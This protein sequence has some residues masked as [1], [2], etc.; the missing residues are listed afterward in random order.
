MNRHPGTPS[1]LVRQGPC[2]WLVFF[3]FSLLFTS[4]RPTTNWVAGMTDDLPTPCRPV[5][6]FVRSQSSTFPSLVG[7]YLSILFSV[8]LPFLFPGISVP[9]TFLSV[10]VFFV[11]PRHMSLPVRH[12]FSDLL[13]SLRH[14]RCPS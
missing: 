12:S 9:N 3:I 5:H 11:S 1:P 14:S 6:H 7:L 4:C 8:V 13:G 10:C 2:N